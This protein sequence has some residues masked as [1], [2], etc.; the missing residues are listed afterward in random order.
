[1]NKLEYLNKK[2]NETKDWT[3]RQILIKR[4]LS[5]SPDVKSVKVEIIVAKNENS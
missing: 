2:V 1:M 4:Y 5:E 3:M